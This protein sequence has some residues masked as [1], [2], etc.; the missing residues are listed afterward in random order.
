M[1]LLKIELLK[2]KANYTLH[3]FLLVYIIVTPLVLALM[4]QFDLSQYN[5]PVDAKEMFK[6][7]YN[8]ELIPYI[9]SWFNLILSIGVISFVSL[10]FS[11]KMY[12]KTFI[13]G[14]NREELYLGKL[15]MTVVLTTF[16]TIYLLILIS[17]FGA[18][19]FDSS[20][21]G[22]IFNLKP[23]LLYFFQAFCYFSF[24]LFLITWLKNAT[25]AILIFIG[26]YFL[27]WIISI[28]I[29]KPFEIFLPFDAFS[30]IVPFPFTDEIKANIQ[31]EGLLSVDAN[32]HLAP[33]ISG[34]YLVLMQGATYLLMKIRAL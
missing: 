20:N 4:G 29:A 24:A 34:V 19:Y 10:E 21:V 18:F 22:Q 7:P 26:Y 1:R 6:F 23:L 30:E 17:S 3:G 27:E 33:Y 5:I 28:P 14:L 11:A 2:L 31:Q 25:T 8:W 32:L 9:A 15:L 12:K 13:D 16:C